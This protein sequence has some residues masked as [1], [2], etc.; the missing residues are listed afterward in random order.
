M[1]AVVPFNFSD[2]AQLAEAIARSGLFGMKTREQALALMAIAH[3][4]GRH[5]AL[6]ARDYDIIQNRPA[7]KSEAML[8]DFLEAGGKVQWNKLDDSVADAT[9][10]HP[11]GGSVRISWD[12]ER[13]RTAGMAGKENWKK[14]P[15]QMLRS[16]TVSEGVRTVYPLATSGMYEPGEAAD[17]PPP[18][19]GPTI[20]AT[21]EPSQPTLREQMNAAVPMG[22]PGLQAVQASMQQG[23]Y[24]ANPKQTIG[25]WL[26]ALELAFRDCSDIHEVSKIIGSD[27]VVKAMKSLTGDAKARLEGIIAGAKAAHAPVEHPDPDADDGWPGPTPESMRRERE[28]A[29]A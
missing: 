16:R 5:P 9:F 20:E 3:A 23:E 11:Q 15:R 10:S 1:N 6:A 26:T 12:M 27:R 29:E 17:M 18:H 4:E 22:Q 21:P 8:R 2:M 19:T 25:D 7:K 14:Y 13:A 28:A 24:A